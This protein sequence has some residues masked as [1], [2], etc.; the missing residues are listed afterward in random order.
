MSSL[1]T[2]SVPRITEPKPTHGHSPSHS[3]PDTRYVPGNSLVRFLGYF[4]IGLGL[5]EVLAPR[6]LAR[7][8]GVHQE[9]IL[10]AYGLREIA[11]GLGIL[12]NSRPTDW[13]WAR[14]AGD[15]LDLATAGMNFTA[16]SGER[17]DRLL[18]TLAALA[19]VTVLDAL[20]AAQLS[21]ADALTDD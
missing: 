7:L 11:C 13:L 2:P 21:A 3:P 16:A 1:L 20:C 9:G 14:V 5:S 15:A 4:S 10:R 8:T 19:G 12:R 17:R 18:A 6:S